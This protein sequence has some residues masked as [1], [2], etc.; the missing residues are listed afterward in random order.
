MSITQMLEA[1][2]TQ[3]LWRSPANLSRS[4]VRSVDAAVC[5]WESIARVLVA[6]RK[7][8]RVITQA[9]VAVSVEAHAWDQ[10]QAVLG[11]NACRVQHG[12]L[13]AIGG[14]RH[15]SNRWAWARASS[16]DRSP[17]RCAKS[18]L[19]ESLEF[20]LI[21]RDAGGRRFDLDE[22]GAAR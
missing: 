5:A 17:R 22:H 4:R 12:H 8:R 11:I 19:D 20:E 2:T 9:T 1:H 21:R 14:Y 6:K 16:I 7:C 3:T 18:A 15:A 13:G 10:V